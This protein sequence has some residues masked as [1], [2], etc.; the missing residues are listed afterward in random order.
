MDVWLTYWPDL[1]VGFVFLAGLSMLV[2]EDW[3][4][5]LGYLAVVYAGA[6]ALI[7]L[8]WPWT[9]AATVLIGGWMAASVLGLSLQYASP[10]EAR[11]RM[12]AR[13]LRLL[14][15]LL[16]ALLALAVAPLMAPWLP[17]MGESYLWGSLVLMILGLWQVGLRSNHPLW[18]VAGLLTVLVG[19]NMLYA[20]LE[21]S[22]L[23][24][25]LMTLVVVALGLVGGYLLLQEVPEAEEE[26][27]L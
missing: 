1:V 23:L 20:F 12:S 9:L 19:F 10:E 5:M 2:A 3:R 7:S 15:G 8:A 27:L 13:V 24:A 14:A 26:V 4:W 21:Q 25:G 22:L 16:A 18:V 6:A 17:K 11:G